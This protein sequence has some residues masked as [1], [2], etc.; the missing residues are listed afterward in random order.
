MALAAAYLLPTMTNPATQ[1]SLP[2]APKRIL[3]AGDSHH[4]AAHI[5]W[6]V[7]AAHERG[8][9]AI[10]SVGDLGYWPRYS[11]GQEFMSTLTARL[12]KR[13]IDLYFVEGNHED[14]EELLDPEHPE[15]GPFR[16]VE[17]AT[18]A[19]G[20]G[21]VWH[22]PR[23]ARWDWQGVRFLGL[24]GAFSIDKDERIQGVD[25]FPEE[26]ITMGQVWQTLETPGETDILV[27]HDCP[28]G[29]MFLNQFEK[30]RH[31]ESAQNTRAVLQ[32]ASHVKPVMVV[33][34]HYHTPHTTEHHDPVN[35]LHATVIGL[36]LNNQL[37]P[38]AS[39][40]TLDLVEYARTLP[41]IRARMYD[42][43]A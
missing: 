19:D 33:H 6:V 9:D 18:R 30:Q 27:A 22:I 14:F 34:G 13:G 5:R 17:P 4:D 35:D 20:R 43:A 8:C 40:M 26:T 1:I 2:P 25:W 29:V 41:E 7:D 28:H 12:T 32:V 21:G 10:V 37:D 42:P 11:Y 23:G 16:L 31:P 39:V 24:G 3:F 36:D 38:R 15:I